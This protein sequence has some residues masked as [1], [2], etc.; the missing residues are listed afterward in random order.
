MLSCSEVNDFKKRVSFMRIIYQVFW[1]HV[2]MHDS[3][4]MAVVKSLKDLLHDF[5]SLSFIKAVFLSEFFKELPPFTQ[6]RNY[7]KEFIILVKFVDF[8]DVW[9]THILK[10]TYF[11]YKFLLLSRALI[12]F[13]YYFYCSEYV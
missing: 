6:L 10:Y 12:H 13:F 11:I 8:Y 3:F 1:F 5:R 9:M 7:V 2:P 4:R